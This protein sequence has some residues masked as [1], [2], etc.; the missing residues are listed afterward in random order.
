MS[1]DKKQ[2][3][4]AIGIAINNAYEFSSSYSIDAAA[5]NIQQNDIISLN[6]T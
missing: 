3:Q 5:K 1:C 4:N 2:K 6:R